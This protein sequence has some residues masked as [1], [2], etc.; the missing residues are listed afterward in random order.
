MSKNL[1]AG[2]TGAVVT[3][4]ILALMGS[5]GGPLARATDPAEMAAR[6]TNRVEGVL[7]DLAPQARA[8]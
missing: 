4:T 1:V 8:V 3:A 5:H 7:D 6:L 2:L